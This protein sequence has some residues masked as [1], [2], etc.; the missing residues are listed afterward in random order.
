MNDEQ[1]KVQNLLDD[2]GYDHPVH[3]RVLDLLSELGEFGKEV[4]LASDYGSTE[5]AV[6]REMIEEFGDLY[7]SV[8][9]VAN[10]LGVELDQLLDSTIRKYRDRAE[11]TGGIGSSGP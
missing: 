6:G 2:L 3:S 11:A 8:L 5:P 7:F 9:T 1:R 4:L 10:S